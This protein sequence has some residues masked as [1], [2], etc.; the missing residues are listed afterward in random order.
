MN[1]TLKIAVAAA[2]AAMAAQAYAQITFY[3]G[4]GWRG[5]AFTAD[6]P[7]RDFARTGFND[8]AS[9]VIVDRGQ[10]EVCDDANFNGR[11][12]VLRRGSYESLRGMGL[13]NSI[14]SVRP[15]RYRARYDG[16]L[17]NVTLA[18]SRDGRI[19]KLDLTR[20]DE[21]NAPMQE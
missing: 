20:V 4:E 3:E 1:K 19:S 17:L 16:G 2:A 5:R 10:W 11:C 6:R 14:S 8:R 12:V 9:S 15:I 21:W 7:V 18:R 13:D